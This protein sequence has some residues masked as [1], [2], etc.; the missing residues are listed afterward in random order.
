MLFVQLNTEQL[1]FVGWGWGAKGDRADNYDIFENKVFAHSLIS[2][3][4]I[5]SSYYFYSKQIVTL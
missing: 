4:V 2:Q 3:S 1:A 5:H